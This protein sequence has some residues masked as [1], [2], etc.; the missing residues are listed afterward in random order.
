VVNITNNTPDIVT[1]TTGPNGEI[2][3]VIERARAA[4]VADIADQMETGNG[5]VG[6]ALAVQTGGRAVAV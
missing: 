3:I 4:A 1:Q 2:D 5:R 6:Q